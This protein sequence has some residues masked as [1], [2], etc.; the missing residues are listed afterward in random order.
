MKVV[1]L[2]TSYPR[3]PEDV[4]GAFVR[5][6]VERLREAGL[7]VRVVSPAV[8]R[9]FGLAYGARDRREPP[10]KAVAGR[11]SS[12]SSCSPSRGRRGGRPA[13]PT[14]SMRTG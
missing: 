13:T 5:D 6:A 14:S 1:V 11:G 3:G 2:T 12:R 7:D 8:F 9:H 4:A 10:A